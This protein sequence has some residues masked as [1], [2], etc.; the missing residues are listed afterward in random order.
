[1]RAILGRASRRQAPSARAPYD[2]QMHASSDPHQLRHAPERRRYELQLDGKL[3][4]FIDYRDQGPVRELLHTEVLPEHEGR[5]IGGRLARFALD[6]ARREG[7][8]VAPTCSFIAAY[9]QRQPDAADLTAG[10]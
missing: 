6:T 5:G 1:M 9:L 8:R 7:H 4:G 3:A 2:V 10:T